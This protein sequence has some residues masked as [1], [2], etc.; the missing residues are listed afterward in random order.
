MMKHFR[1]LTALV[2]AILLAV[3]LGCAPD[4]SPTAPEPEVQASLLGGVLGGVTDVVGGVVQVVGSVASALLDPLVCP[5]NRSY[6]STRT[7]GRSGGTIWVGD[8]RLDI[9]SGAL[10]SDTRITATA[11][12]G[13]YAEVRFEPHG[14]QFNKP[15]TLTISYE[16][17]GLLKRSSVPVIVYTDDDRNILEVLKTEI[18]RYQKT[19]SG[20]TDHF[21]GYLLAE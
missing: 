3:P 15:V 21:S 5:A 9:P 2:V 4:Q 17:C 19:V 13:D 10:S 11:P 8:H 18:N 20:K 14:L 7:I 12:R 6:S 1:S 16:E